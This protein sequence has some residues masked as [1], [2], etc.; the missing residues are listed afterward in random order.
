MTTREIADAAGVS[1]ETVRRAAKNLFPDKIENGKTS[2]FSKEEA[3]C[4]MRDI[5]LLNFVEVAKDMTSTN[6]EVSSKN[7]EVSRIDRLESMVEKLLGAVAVIVQANAMPKQIAFE[8][9]YMSIQAYATTHNIKLA[10]SEALAIG[11]NAA[12]LSREKGVEIRKVTDERFGFV[13]SYS[14]DILKEVFTP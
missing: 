1:G 4:I 13:G 3:I 2:R 14:V 8:Q 11:K 5:R 6:M 10:F 12:K 9:D 7:V